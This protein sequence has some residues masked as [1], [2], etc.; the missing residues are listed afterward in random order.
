MLPRYHIILGAIFT[1]VFWIVFP[2]TEWYYIALIF[3]SS[4]LI[5]FDHYMNAVLKTR[6]MG[7]FKAFAYHKKLEKIDLAE[8][9]RGIR[10]KGDLHVF[11]TL[12]FTALTFALGLVWLPFLYVFIGMFFHSVVDLISLAFEDRLY[13]RE[14]FL[15][16]WIRKKLKD[17]RH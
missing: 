14:Y 1:L 13:R 17:D 4:F 6:K 3:L 2:W 16:N 10:R 12:E 7:L 5:D 15:T 9:K 8:Y 11:H